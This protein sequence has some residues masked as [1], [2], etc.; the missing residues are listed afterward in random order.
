[1]LENVI[2]LAEKQIGTAEEQPPRS[3]R[4]IFGE[5]Y[6][7]NGVPW[8]VIFIW[9]IFFMLKL[10]R[11]FYGGKRCASCSQLLEWAKETGQTVRP[12]EAQRGDVLFFDFDGGSTP[13]HCGIL[14]ERVVQNG[15]EVFYSIEGNTPLPGENNDGV[16]IKTR[17]LSQIVGVWR[18]RYDNATDYDGR[19]SYQAIREALEDGALTGYPDGS[20][21]PDKPVTREE[22]AQF[23]VNIKNLRRAK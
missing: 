6:G 13:E 1:M 11:L 5:A 3:N 14:R 7:V 10:A 22:L 21:K 12:S 20:F 18:P 17:N 15:R 2:N 16:A 19:W 4:T 9:W 8:C 23:Y